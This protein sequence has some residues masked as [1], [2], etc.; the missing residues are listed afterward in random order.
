M[1]LRHLAWLPLSLVLAG[2]INLGLSGEGDTRTL[3]YFVMEDGGRAAP[4]A[5]PTPA[6]YTLLIADTTAGAFYDTDGMAYSNASGTRGYYQFARWSQRS[7]KRF[8]DLLLARIEKE[9]IFA[10]V[11][12]PGSNVRG[13]WLLTTEILDFH[14]DAV[15]QPGTVKMELRAEVVDLKLR[16]LLARKTFTQ[17]VAV[18]SYDAA[19]AHKAFNEAATR[20]LNDLSD[21]LKELASRP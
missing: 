9:K 21:W 13:D 15:R 12:Q 6:P 5:I 20:T 8:T 1:P 11:A 10:T 7:G 3:T 19:G 17:S 16:K 14:H 18:P 4:A 2:C